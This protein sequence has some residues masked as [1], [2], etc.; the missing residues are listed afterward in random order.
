MGPIEK[1]TV[2]TL[3]VRG[4]NKDQMY[5]VR[6]KSKSPGFVCYTCKSTTVCVCD[7]GR[8]PSRYRAAGPLP[9]AEAAGRDAVTLHHPVLSMG[10][11]EVEQVAAAIRKTYR[12]A[13]RLR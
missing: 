1:E 5:L 13:A 6:K 7:L 12:N 9:N 4:R 3:K 2:T 8:G 10:E 11:Q